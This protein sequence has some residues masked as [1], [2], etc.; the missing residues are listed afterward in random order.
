MYDVPVQA[1]NRQLPVADQSFEDNLNTE[2][3]NETSALGMLALTYGHSSDSE[4]DN[5]EADAALHADDAK[6]MICSSEDRYQFENSSLTSSE[7]CKNSAT[8]NHDS[9]SFSVNTADQMHFQ[10]NDYEEFGRARFDSKNS[11]NCSSEFESDG[12]G[13]TKKNGL[14]TRYQDSHVNGKSSL[15]ADTDKPMFD[16]SAEPV[17]IENMPFAPDIDEDSSRLHVFCLEHA[18]EVEQQ[19]RPIGG[20]HILLLCHPGAIFSHLLV[21]VI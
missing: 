8:L 15:D 5:A 11:F 9:S 14:S 20:V 6:L 2:K 4:E 21:L 16:K 13:S 3:R 19:L 10:V 17:E 1:V 18:K 7:Y 12:I